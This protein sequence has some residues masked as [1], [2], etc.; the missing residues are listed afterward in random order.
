MS[1]HV[2][3]HIDVNMAYVVLSYV[4][5]ACFGEPIVFISVMVENL[6]ISSF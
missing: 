5:L 4:F 3:A 2:P 1:V 6:L